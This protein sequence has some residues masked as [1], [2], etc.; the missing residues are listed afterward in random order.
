[1]AG[2][3]N[4]SPWE[5]GSLQHGAS[6]ILN[7]CRG[8]VA[9]FSKEQ[10]G[11]FDEFVAQ[12]EIDPRLLGSN[13]SPEPNEL[14]Q[15]PLQ[16]SHDYDGGSTTPNEASALQ[17]SAVVDTAYQPDNADTYS[18]AS[19]LG[20]DPYN[21][22]S[23]VKH[24]P[25]PSGLSSQ[26]EFNIDDRN[27]HP[28]QYVDSYQPVYQYPE[29]G[30]NGRYE[31]T[32]QLSQV[33][34]NPAMSMYG[35]AY[36][37][38]MNQWYQAPFVPGAPLNLEPVGAC[39]SCGCKPHTG[40]CPSPTF[41]PQHPRRLPD[42]AHVESQGA[43][44]RKCSD[45]YDDS[46]PTGRAT[47]V[48]RRSRQRRKGQG[49]G[50]KENGKIEDARLVYTQR[51][52]QVPSWTSEQGYE[53]S[54]TRQG[55]WES[56]IMLSPDQL[57]DYVNSCPR[58]L[59]IWLQQVPPQ[60][61]DRGDDCDKECRYQGCPIPNRTMLAGWHRVAFDEFPELTSEGIKDPFK[62][63]GAMHLW[64]FERCIDP[65]E[66]F[67]TGALE[68]DERI[69]PEEDKNRMALNHG[70]NT[71]I[72]SISVEPWIEA[73]RSK[74]G[75]PQIP[76]ARHE[77]SLS[78][79]LV[80]HHI[81]HQTGARQKTRNNRNGKK[82]ED[83]RK[84]I[85]YHLG[86]LDYY[87]L[88]CKND[89]R[90]KNGLR[91][92]PYEEDEEDDEDNKENYEEVHDNNK[93][94]NFKAIGAPPPA[95]DTTNVPITNEQFDKFTTDYETKSN[96]MSAPAQETE[97]EKTRMAAD[98]FPTPDSL[99]S[100]AQDVIDVIPSPPDFDFSEFNPSQTNGVIISPSIMFSPESTKGNH[101][102]SPVSEPQEPVSSEATKKEQPGSKTE[103]NGQVVTPPPMKPSLI[104][105]SVS[106]KRAVQGSPLRRSSR[107]SA[108][109]TP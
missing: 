23:P 20:D 92:L 19:G 27:W 47:K 16:G 74:G 8:L 89:Y 103:S 25:V 100:K 50:R 58:Q 15:P 31:H 49:P 101:P 28:T 73:R 94:M 2:P 53:F 46:Y 65:I 78:Y 63:A 17:T 40:R 82:P 52:D 54:Y 80:N 57:R 32:L 34:G 39:R 7:D 108:K 56:D 71:H 109:K 9:P 11:F 102:P 106:A 72:M 62:M 18:V 64:C 42:V 12:L 107:V 61:K 91:E 33:T 30:L 43:A 104:L 90:R 38:G 45:R 98:R 1:M 29:Q 24:E 26:L 87:H 70:H 75:P 55:Q 10:M 3:A 6:N 66:L 60:S 96:N 86:R 79:A 41:P 84:T 69:L 99:V 88:L 97:T 95:D 36:D 4:S 67:N 37:P 83:C 13:S 48:P 77:D 105:P 5:P 59:T 35:L 93:S 68:A 51:L 22:T 44:K 85:E 21:Q 14:S 76:S 81:N